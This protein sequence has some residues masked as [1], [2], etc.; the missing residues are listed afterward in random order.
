MAKNDLL[1]ASYSAV[2]RK[3]VF[4][5]YREIAKSVEQYGFRFLAKFTYQSLS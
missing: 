2:L 4:H 5:N 1:K 3:Q